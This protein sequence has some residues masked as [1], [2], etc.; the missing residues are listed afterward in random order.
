M[1]A[2][3]ILNVGDLEQSKRF[4]STAEKAVVLDAPAHSSPS[5]K[6]A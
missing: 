5:R 4:F 3:V 6:P 1:I 2:H